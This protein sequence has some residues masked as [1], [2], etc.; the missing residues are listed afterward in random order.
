ML[1]MP[2]NR[3]KES[4]MK[5]SAGAGLILIQAVLLCLSCKNSEKNSILGPE[6]LGVYKDGVYEGQLPKDT[7]GY[8]TS[9]LIEVKKGFI[10]TIGWNIYDTNLKRYFDAAYEQVY[11]GNDTYI[12]QC[13]DNMKGMAAYGSKLIQTQNVDS[14]DVITGA[15]WCYNKFKQVVKVTLKDAKKE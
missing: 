11:T 13:R 5:K 10:R 14:V 2:F 12:R 9:A 4:L 3:R 15:T 6:P 1:F 7:E 8:N